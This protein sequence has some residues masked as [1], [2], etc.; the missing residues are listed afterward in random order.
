M[1]LNSQSR[2]AK[3]ANKAGL[4]SAVLKLKYYLDIFYFNS[5]TRVV[6][7]HTYYISVANKLV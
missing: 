1:I 4:I 5:L 6:N 3:P 2:N 7:A